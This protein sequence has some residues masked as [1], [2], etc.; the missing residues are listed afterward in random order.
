[1]AAPPAAPPPLPGGT[2]PRWHVAIDGAAAGPFAQ[3]DLLR[4][5]A[6]GRLT[7]ATLVWTEGQD[8][9]LE[10]GQVPALATIL[11]ATPPPLPR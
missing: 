10:A 6:E 7:P 11:G 9:W 4:L 3:S 2:A 1:P 8:G 5:V